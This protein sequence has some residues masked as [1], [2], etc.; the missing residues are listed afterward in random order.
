M[1]YLRENPEP[2]YDADWMRREFEKVEQAFRQ[3]QLEELH[4]E[5]SKPR[6]GMLVLADGS[7]W[8]PGSGQGVYAYYNGVWNKLG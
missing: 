4:V 8:D 7:D 6:E 3:L 2:H 5:P 1:S